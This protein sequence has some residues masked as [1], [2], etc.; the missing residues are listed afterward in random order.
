MAISKGTFT[1]TLAG[2]GVTALDGITYTFTLDGYGHQPGEGS[3][4]NDP[5]SVVVT[6]GALSVDLWLC[7][8]GSGATGYFVHR[9]NGAGAAPTEVGFIETSLAGSRDIAT[10]LAASG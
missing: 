4:T 8:S 3:V 6:A 10:L 9:I 2:E 7:D 1:W 5:T